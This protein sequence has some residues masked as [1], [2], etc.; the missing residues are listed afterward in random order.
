[1]L[2][3]QHMMQLCGENSAAHLQAVMDHV[4]RQHRGSGRAIARCIVR[5]PGNL[6]TSR[7]YM[8]YLCWYVLSC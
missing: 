5:P 1:M 4:A 7:H 6:H 3:T 2:H 8:H